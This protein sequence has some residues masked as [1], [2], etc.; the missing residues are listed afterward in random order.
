MEIKKI[1]KICLV[2]MGLGPVDFQELTQQQQEVVNKLV[3]AFN[4]AYCE[5]VTTYMPLTTEEEVVVQDG[6]VDCAA[7]SRQM[8]YPTR[9]VD[10]NGAK[11]RYR[12]LPTSVVTDFSGEGVMT[13]AYSPDEYALDD[14]LDDL[15]FTAE[16]L[17]EGT[18]GV[19]FFALRAFDL[20]SVHDDNFRVAVK[21]MK[22][23]GRE[24]RI[25]ERRW[26]A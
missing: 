11:H 13:Y 20:A 4:V 5:A 10:K 18:L 16:I 9:L 8:V 25:K 14:V 15:R 3:D 24:I 23:N 2:K 12:L 1:I 7:L 6:V 26:G 17:A 21:K 22:Y 19:Y